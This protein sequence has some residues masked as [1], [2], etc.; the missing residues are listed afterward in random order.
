MLYFVEVIRYGKV[1][2]GVN[3]YGI[4]DDFDKIAPTM[5]EY[6]IWRGGKYPVYF[7]TTFDTLNPTDTEFPPRALYEV[8]PPDAIGGEE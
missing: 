5:T 1:A 3:R 8:L 4:F 6:N 7:V 2:C